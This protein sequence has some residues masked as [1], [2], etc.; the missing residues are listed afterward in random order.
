MPRTGCRPQGSP[1]GE[2]LADL[3]ERRLVTFFGC[4]SDHQILVANHLF[5]ERPGH[6]LPG[7]K[8]EG[9]AAFEVAPRQPG[10]VG[11]NPGGQVAEGLA[12]E[13]SIL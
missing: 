10:W 1:P 3:P 6:S 2:A 12:S 11:G 5:T 8:L 13:V 4:R 7:R 9:R